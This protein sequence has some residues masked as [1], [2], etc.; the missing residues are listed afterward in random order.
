M[1]VKFVDLA[2]LQILHK[3]FIDHTDKSFGESDTDNKN[4][5]KKKNPSVLTLRCKSTRL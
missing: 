1:K 5:V 3:A 2:L 4:K